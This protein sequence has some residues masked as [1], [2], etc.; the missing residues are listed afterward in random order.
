MARSAKLKP[1]NKAPDGPALTADGEEVSLMSYVGERPLLLTFLRHFGCIH[2]REWLADL[3]AHKDAIDEAGLN[4]LAVALGQPKHA[5]HFGDKL[6]PSVDCVTNEEP[7]LYE[8]YGIGRGHLLQLVAPD[9]VLAGARAAG[10]GHMQGKATGDR[11]RL[12]ATFIVDTEG[13]IR[14]AYYGKHAGDHPDLPALL[15]W[16]QVEGQ[17]PVSS[18]IPAV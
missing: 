18:T 17:K 11:Q 1:G 13:T 9:A 5:R 8:A 10:K 12:T 4:V 7:D 15:K 16:W 2:C 3:E 6:A 14:Y